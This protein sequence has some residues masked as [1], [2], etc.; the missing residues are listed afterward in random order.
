MT[1]GAFLLLYCSSS[2]EGAMHAIAQPLGILYLGAIFEKA[3]VE[4]SCID[5]RIST[6]ECIEEAIRQAD[7]VGLSAM[8]PDIARALAWAAFA[9]ARG[10]TT[11][12]G[13][14]HATVDPHS[15]LDSGFVDYVFIGESEVTLEEALPLLGDKEKLKL[16][17]GL[18]FFD[19]DGEKI[20]TEARMFTEDLDA[21]PFPARHLLP[22]DEYFARNKSH[23]AY[24]YT[25]RGCPYSC[26][27]CQK[28]ITGRKYRARSV[29]DVCDE[30]EQMLGEHDVGEIMFIDELFTVKPPRVTELCDEIVRRKI[31]IDWVCE[32]RVD[33]IDYEMMMKMRSAGMRRLYLGVET[34]SPRSLET[35]QKRFT[36]DKVLETLHA[37]RRAHLWTKIFLIIGTPGE[38]RED[39]ELTAGM[40]RKGH[41]D[42][43]RSALFNPL[44]GSE[45]FEKYHDRIDF[46]LIF[47]EYV[48]SGGAPYKHEN[49]TVD[50][51]NEIDRTLIENYEQWYRRPAQRLERLF[52]RLRFYIANPSHLLHRFSHPRPTLH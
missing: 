37:A 40:L 15:L 45:S 42:M 10:K 29:E 7:V 17:K 49:F 23:L 24:L 19:D 38:T 14:P 11:M 39:F 1:D 2:P 22:M 52:W 4:V 33:R 36:V 16:V 43:I 47:K 5:E 41:P 3:G 48:A 9:K 6:A 26:V 25:S 21:A 31:E 30:M 13:G 28:A 12:I 34:G 18:G 46:D 44:I 35:L 27:F 51:L 50:E 20:I 32:T 8:T